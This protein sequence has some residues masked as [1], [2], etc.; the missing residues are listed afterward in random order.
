MSLSGALALPGLLEEEL[1]ECEVLAMRQRWSWV[2]TA[3]T[4]S[5]LTP[6]KT[7]KLVSC[8]AG[9]A[10]GPYSGCQRSGNVEERP[11]AR[12]ASALASAW[13]SGA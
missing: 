4:R 7:A 3:V 1:G 8:S 13:S 9:C 2:A 10:M 5:G 12:A 6:L 11:E